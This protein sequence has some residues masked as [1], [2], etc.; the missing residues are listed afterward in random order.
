MKP[1]T[2]KNRRAWVLPKDSHQNSK[3]FRAIKEMAK[4]LKKIFFLDAVFNYPVPLNPCDLKRL[5]VIG[6][7]C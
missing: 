6:T 7:P 1:D 3:D 4:A 2:I 5:I